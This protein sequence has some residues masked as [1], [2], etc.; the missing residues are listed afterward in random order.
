M[1]QGKRSDFEFGKRIGGGRFS[2]VYRCIAKNISGLEGLEVAIK[3]VEPE[4]DV[5]PH[6]VRNELKL[7]QKLAESRITDGTAQNV[8]PLLAFFQSSIE[9]GLVFP[10][11]TVDLHGV[12]AHYTKY[13]SNFNLED[14]SITKKAQNNL[15]IAQIKRIFTGLLRGLAFIHRNGII[16]RDINPN[17]I[18]FESTENLQ[19]V[20]IDFGISYQEPNNNGLEKPDS[21]ITDIATGYYKAPELLLSVRNYTNK[22][23]IWSAGVILMLI[24]SQGFTTPY[25]TD[26]AHSDLALLASIFNTFGT[27]P[28]D[29]EEVKSSRSY[30]AM[31][32][33]F[34][35]KERTPADNLLSK[36][37]D[38]KHFI[39]VFNDMMV[40]E[41]SKRI[42]ATEALAQLENS[43]D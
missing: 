27:P 3:V 30:T 4:D 35:K 43:I 36:L 19:P 13:R 41:S 22:V 18:M 20:I 37:K 29:W 1:Q 10:L 24:A 28:E 17:N 34:F 42:A 7:L 6:N 2:D 39:Q 40:Y 5:P 33:A 16:H 21:K 11:Y 14:G 8:V 38:N 32:A 26:S 9:I 15:S 23:D 12:M 25:S 31:N